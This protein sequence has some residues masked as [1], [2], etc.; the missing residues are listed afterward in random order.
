MRLPGAG[1]RPCEA[2]P[3]LS[4]DDDTTLT[5]TLRRGLRLFAQTD[6]QP[7]ARRAT[8]VILLGLSCLSLLT[9]ALLADPDPG[10]SNAVS[11]FFAALPHT[12]EGLWQTM[13]DLPMVWAAIILVGALVPPSPVDRP[14]HGAVRDPGRHRLAAA[15]ADGRR[16]VAGV[17]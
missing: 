11:D 17:L 14:G 13:A 10:F 3:V 15:R 2:K 4:A 8:D 1:A 12:L 7:R 16:R 6:D 5:P 9:V